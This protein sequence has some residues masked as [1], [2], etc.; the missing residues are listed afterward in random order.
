MKLTEVISVSRSLSHQ[1]GPI[2]G[3][4]IVS[5]PHQ[6]VSSGLVQRGKVIFSSFLVVAVGPVEGVVGLVVVFLRLISLRL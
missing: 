3:G 2:V 6:D 4:L 5:D 1:S